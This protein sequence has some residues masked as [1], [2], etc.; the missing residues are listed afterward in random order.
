MQEQ[1]VS[2]SKAITVNAVGQLYVDHHHW[3]VCWL[4]K[5][6]GAVHHADDF[7]HDTFL[8][9][10]LAPDSKILREPKAY[11][12]ATATNLM[13]DAARR[14]KLEQA[15]LESLMLISEDRY[16]FSAEQYQ[17][18][19]ETLNLLASML[20]GL[21]DKPRRAFLM[22]QFEDLSYVEIADK[23]GVS[24]SMVKQYLAKV[25]VHCYTLM[26]RMP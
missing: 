4:R 23:L 12:A 17:E 6:L 21:P 8:R 20:G 15:Y 18:A 25:M 2:D 10:L 24:V 22:S 16:E 13:I 7:A 19:I 14:R 3:L 1:S 9:I 5:K 26:H 11:L